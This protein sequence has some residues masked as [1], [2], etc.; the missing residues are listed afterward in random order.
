MTDYELK[1]GGRC[2][3]QVIYCRDELGTADERLNVEFSTYV[4]PIAGTPSTCTA[5]KGAIG[6]TR[7][8]SC[9]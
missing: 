7:E 2:A 9:I 6:F 4:V 3:V 8:R 5:R 1:I